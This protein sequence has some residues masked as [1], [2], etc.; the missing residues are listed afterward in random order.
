MYFVYILRCR[1]DRLYTGI[2]TDIERRFRRRQARRKIHKGESAAGDSRFMELRKQK[3]RFK[4]GI[5]DKKAFA[6]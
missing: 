6:H 2:T 4:T 1:G 5:G 3:Y